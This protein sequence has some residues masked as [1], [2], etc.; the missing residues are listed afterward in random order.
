L[1]WA[2][3]P[4]PKYKGGKMALKDYLSEYLG[5]ATEKKLGFDVEGAYLGVV[6]LTLEKCG[7]TNESDVPMDKLHK[8]GVWILWDQVYRDLMLDWFDLNADGSSYKRSQVVESV[9]FQLDKAYKET[10]KY[11]NPIM[12]TSHPIAMSSE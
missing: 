1:E 12:I 7:A 3:K 5:V 4:T 8:I 6:N 11:L 10:K 2:S 9:K